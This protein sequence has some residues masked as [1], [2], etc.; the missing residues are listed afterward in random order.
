MSRN[1]LNF[2]RK[3]DWLH[4]N[5]LAFD[6][7]DSTITVSGRNQGLVKISWKDELKWIMAPKKFWSKS[8][9]INNGPNTEPF[10]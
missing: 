8:G 9:R 2:L 3:G 10:L 5:G 7:K 1:D 4:M 6:V